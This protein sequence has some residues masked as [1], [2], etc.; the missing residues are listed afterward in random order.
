MAEQ[1]IVCNQACTVTVQHEFVLPIL[2]LDS[3]AAAQIA[4]AIIGV[5]A[6]GF[7]IRAAIQTARYRAHPEE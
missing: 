7:G 1:T 6:I 2:N 3:V 4:A 5:W